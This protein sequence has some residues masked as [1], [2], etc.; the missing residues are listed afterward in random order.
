MKNPAIEIDKTCNAIRDI[1]IEAQIG[2]ARV[3]NFTMVQAYWNIGRVIIEKE[4]KGSKR[5]EY[6]KALINDL[7]AKLVK[8]F[9]KGF[10]PR[11]L[12]N[13]RQ[14]YLYF[15]KWHALSAK[16]KISENASLRKEL[17]WTHYKLLL[18]IENPE[19]R[20]WY[21]NEAADCGWS[22][23]ALDR[24]INSFYYERILASKNKSSVRREAD[25]KTEKLIPEQ[26]LK[27]PYVLEFLDLKD[28]SDY[29]ESD[30]EKALIDKL[31][32]FLLE[33]G[34][35]FCFVSRQK[36][37]L[38][39]DEEFNIDLVFYKY[40][41]KCFVLIDLKI[42]KLTHQDIGQMDMYIRMYEDKFKLPDDNPSLGI[43]LCSEK[44]NAVVKYSILNDNKQLFA[45]KYQ[46]YLPSETEL[47]NTLE[48]ERRLIE[49]QYNTGD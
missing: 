16:S 23:R 4:Q 10:T 29:H 38:A 17:S 22:T 47:A 6:G 44:N 48:R 27:D 36:R 19:A 21:M 25:E 31:Q 35:G 32:E 34:K 28:R 43:I 24:Q 41:L 5:A 1:L 30:L 49:N 39:E 18:R 46:L 11:N 20:E 45:S 7:S 13:M 37:I 12:R 15:P 2:V 40:L 14:F 42:G 26:I 33:L 8:E 9:G 3:I